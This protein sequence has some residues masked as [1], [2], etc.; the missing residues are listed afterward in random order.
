MTELENKLK[1]VKEEIKVLS[2]REAELL[3]KLNRSH[4]LQVVR[5]LKERKEKELKVLRLSRAVEECKDLNDFEVNV[6]HTRSGLRKR[7]DRKIEI[8]EGNIH[9]LID[10]Y[11]YFAE[12]SDKNLPIL[13]IGTREGWFLK[14]LSK[15]GYADVRGIEISPEAVAIAKSK[16]LNVIET[17]VRE[18]TFKEEFGTIT[19][20]HTI[21]HCSNPQRVIEVVYGTLK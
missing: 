1:V 19:L 2:K 3:D 20:I 7:K 15:V 11:M 18:M 14:F 5:K 9:R 16:G 10:A 12:F 17:D 21:E 6:I 4:R 13:D 8:S